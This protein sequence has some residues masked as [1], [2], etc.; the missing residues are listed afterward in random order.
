MRDYNPEDVANWAAGQAADDVAE[1]V[2]T[3]E[4]GGE[5]DVAELAGKMRERVDALRA[6]ADD[7]EK[8]QGEHQQ[9]A[10]DAARVARELADQ[11]EVLAADIDT[12][13][14]DEDAEEAADDSDEV[15]D[16]EGADDLED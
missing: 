8:V 15:P 14:A 2:E 10:Q 1:D 11:Y 3:E 6:D 12:A 9:E 16:D 4:G 7:L 13:A 5:L